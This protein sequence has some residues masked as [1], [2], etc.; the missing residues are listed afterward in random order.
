MAQ[1][2]EHVAEWAL[3]HSFGDLSGAIEHVL[4]NLARAPPTPPAPTGK[5]SPNEKR[6]CLQAGIA[7]PS[8]TLPGAQVG[9]GTSLSAPLSQCS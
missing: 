8:F 5:T 1:V 9:Q 2:K 3:A 7:I 4:E 6:H